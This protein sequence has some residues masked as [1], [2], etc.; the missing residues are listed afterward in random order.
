M[1]LDNDHSIV[2]IYLLQNGRYYST[3]F[4]P[5]KK[6]SKEKKLS[7][8][9]QKFLQKREQEERERKRAEQEKVSKLLAMRDEKSKNKI[10]K[11]LKVTK[12]A[13]KSVLDDVNTDQTAV[14]LQGA[15]QPDQDDYGYVSTTANAFY[16]NYIEKVG[17]SVEGFYM[18]L[19]LSISILGKRCQ[20]GQ[21][22]CS[23]S[24]SIP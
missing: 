15:D 22:I 23:Q 8:N 21:R 7:D 2:F 10:R 13:N 11:M 1:W 4:A 9:I 16:Q 24:S 17:G 20:G 6:E 18:F 12:S 19:I 5:P 14:T 3:K